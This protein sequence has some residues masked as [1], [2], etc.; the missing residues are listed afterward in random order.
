MKFFDWWNPEFESE[1]DYRLKT[2]AEH[3][4]H[5]WCKLC[6]EL[7]EDKSLNYPVKEEIQTWW[8]GEGSRDPP[9]KP[10]ERVVGEDVCLPIRSK[11]LVLPD[12]MGNKKTKRS[13]LDF[14]YDE[15]DEDNSF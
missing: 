14:N 2:L 10:V 11:P 15:I 4:N 9:K 13:V 7:M 12:G 3:R 5:G 6:K 1:N 8:Y